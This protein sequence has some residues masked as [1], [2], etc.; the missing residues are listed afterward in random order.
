MPSNKEFTGPLL[1]LGRNCCIFLSWIAN[2]SDTPVPTDFPHIPRELPRLVALSRLLCYFPHLWR[3]NRFICVKFIR[4]RFNQIDGVLVTGQQN[5]RCFWCVS[6]PV[7]EVQV[8]DQREPS[9]S[10]ILLS[11]GN[12]WYI[13]NTCNDI[14]KSP[15]TREI[16]HNN[17]EVSVNLRRLCKMMIYLK[18]FWFARVAIVV[19][20]SALSLG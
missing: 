3:F 17:A 7:K 8:V 10:K 12:L 14:R 1:H 6:K 18:Y 11:Y 20:R 2:N 5:R 4:Q 15:S 19:L 13:G 16:L 9:A